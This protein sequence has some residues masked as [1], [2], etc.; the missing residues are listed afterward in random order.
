VARHR[1]AHDREQEIAVVTSALFEIRIQDRFIADICCTVV[2]GDTAPAQ[3]HP[4]AERTA[5]TFGARAQFT[6][7]E[8]IDERHLPTLVQLRWTILG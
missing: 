3:A 8:A 4:H 5:T 1:G 2:Q 7:A 6:E